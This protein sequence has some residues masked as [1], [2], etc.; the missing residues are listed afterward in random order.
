MTD[1]LLYLAR[2]LSRTKRKDYEN[3]VLGAVWNRLSAETRAHIKPVSQQTVRASDGGLFYLDLFFP[4]LN[5]A[6]EC[7]EL[8]HLRQK[9]DDTLRESS[10]RATL[11]PVEDPDVFATIT[12]ISAD[13]GCRILRVPVPEA[14]KA[15]GKGPAVSAP[16]HT[17][18]LEAFEKAIDAQVAEIEAASREARSRSGFVSW[19]ELDAR[20]EPELF[21][22]ERTEF[23]VE[24]AV[25]FSTIGEICNVLL[26]AGYSSGL[27]RTRGYFT[28]RS[29]AATR[30][31][32]NDL[33]DVKLWCPSEVRVS[34]ARAA[35]GNT[36]SPDGQELR[37]HDRRSDA[38]RAKAG[39]AAADHP[40]ITFLKVKDPVTGRSGYRF[41]GLFRPHS[42]DGA[43]RV[44]RRSETRFPLIGR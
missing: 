41:V 6:V 2:T 14:P 9:A 44:Y 22:R 28:P 38:E 15:A 42:V 7:D 35:W 29:L 18:S 11:D 5:I 24:D 36:I 23:A 39:R 12:A 16:A 37:E 21:Y 25:V 17:L 31:S 40:R 8:H 27:T 33:S 26:G 13:A 43:V 10:V 34:G 3:Y 4:Q 1:R 30:R 19:N 20:D 32:S